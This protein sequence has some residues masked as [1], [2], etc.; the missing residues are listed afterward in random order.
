MRAEPVES[1]VPM[2]MV[3]RAGCGVEEKVGDDFEVCFG[4]SWTM[5]GIYM[6]L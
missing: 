5:V 2:I 1:F 4:S 6:L 3:A